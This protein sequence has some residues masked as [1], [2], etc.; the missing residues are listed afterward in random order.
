M[1][2]RVQVI[3]VDDITGEETADGGTTVKFGVDGIDYE[4][5]LNDKNLA[6]FREAIQFYQNHA[7]RIGGR[8][9]TAGGA[10]KS[11]GDKVQLT[12]VRS[13][14]NENGF[15]VSARGRISSEV[16]QAYQDAHRS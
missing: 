6:K 7:R 9:A 3:L 13:W 11:S 10:T 15:K 16:Q 4:I 8:R 14:A 12:A 2:Q 1:A 5:D